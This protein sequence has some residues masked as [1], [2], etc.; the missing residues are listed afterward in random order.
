MVRS[1]V[2][3]QLC[4]LKLFSLIVLVASETNISLVITSKTNPSY[5]LVR[6]FRKLLIENL[7]VVT[8]Q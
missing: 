6:D 5:G 4:A 2:F 8:L 1:H 7:P 3:G